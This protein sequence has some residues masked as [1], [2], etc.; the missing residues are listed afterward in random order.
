MVKKQEDIQALKTP[1]LAAAKI[2]RKEK[3]T[4]AERQLFTEERLKHEYDIQKNPL[5]GLIP[6]E[7]KNEELNNAVLAREKQFSYRP[8]RANNFS[9]LSSSVYASRGPSN[10]GGRTRALVVDKSDPTSN[11]IIAGGVSGGVFR[12][13]NGGNSWVKVSAN[14]E[15]HNVTAIAQD[16]R[17]G[18]ENIWYYGTGERVREQ[19]YLGR[20]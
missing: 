6:Q 9:V 10:F 19:C 1:I 18:F 3:K 11:T 16:P 14:D 4:V 7:E 5:T 17:A 2:E 8:N 20:I 13:T 12:T 15:I